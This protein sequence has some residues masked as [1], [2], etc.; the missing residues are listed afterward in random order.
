MTFPY[1]TTFCS[2]SI[3]FILGL[4][5]KKQFNY[6]IQLALVL[7]IWI[8][9]PSYFQR[10]G[11]GH[12][13]V[14]SRDGQDNGIRV[15]DELKDELSYLKFNVFRLITNRHLEKKNNMEL[16]KI[17]SLCLHEAW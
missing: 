4:S 13:C 3:S 5:F 14:S 11:S 12:V 9:L 6:S 17:V 1:L 10:F 8:H 16:L 15:A 2:N 7:T